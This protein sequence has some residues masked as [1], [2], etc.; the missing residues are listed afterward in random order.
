MT[1]NFR[2][3]ILCLFLMLS[4][5]ANWEGGTYIPMQQDFD[6]I[7]LAHIFAID[8]LVSEFREHTGRYP[9]QESDERNPVASIIETDEQ[10]KSHRGDVPIFITLETRI[11]YNNPPPEPE[12]VVIKTVAELENELSEGLGR[13]I[14]LPKDPQRVPMNKPSV[15]LYS[16]YLGVY[17]ITAFLHN[18][19][20]FARRIGPYFYKITLSNASDN[21]MG[22]WTAGKLKSEDSLRDFLSSPFNKEGYI[23]K[24]EFQAD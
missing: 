12:H 19:Q 20:D 4:A 14:V 15:Y 24:A 5:C 22:I 2:L 9:F 16:Y 6:K 23:R 8:D 13:D 1:R 18:K 3:P 17:E 10:R 11:D 21:S 7:R